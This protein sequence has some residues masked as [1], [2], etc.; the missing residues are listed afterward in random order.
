MHGATVS[1]ASKTPLLAVGRLPLIMRLRVP[2]FRDPDDCNGALAEL[3]LLK[4]DC[5][6]D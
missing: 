4:T 6:A 1:V 2:V 5:R 3:T